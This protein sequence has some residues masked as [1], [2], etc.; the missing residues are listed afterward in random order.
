MFF[1]RG[2]TFILNN[3][4]RK[5]TWCL[6]S[7]NLVV[8]LI[9]Q[10]CNFS[11]LEKTE[12]AINNECS[13]QVR[14]SVSRE[15]PVTS[16]HTLSSVRIIWSLGWSRVVV[17]GGRCRQQPWQRSAILLIIYCSLSESHGTL[18]GP[19]LIPS[20]SGLCEVWGVRR[21]RTCVWRLQ[22]TPGEGSDVFTGKS[23]SQWKENYRA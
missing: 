12:L 3:I 8:Y 15:T 13:C 19:V 1:I 23:T 6:T 14:G 11:G 17:V 20:P 18:D 10:R 2:K 4:N 7:R 22:D 5:M 9:G 16:S 21:N